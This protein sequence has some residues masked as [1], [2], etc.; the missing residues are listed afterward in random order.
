MQGIVAATPFLDQ[1]QDI[2]LDGTSQRNAG[3]ANTNIGTSVN[4][5]LG[6]AL[7]G[8]E[9]TGERICFHKW[10]KSNSFTALKIELSRRIVE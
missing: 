9:E 5:T 8:E 4:D 10:T 1:S 6:G 3:V 7:L 2:V